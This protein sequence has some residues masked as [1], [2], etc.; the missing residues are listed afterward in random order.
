MHGAGVLRTCG[1]SLSSRSLERPD[2]TGGA[3]PA[4]A[5]RQSSI[6]ASVMRMRRMV[7]VSMP[8]I[9]RMLV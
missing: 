3:V 8:S 2:I 1:R 5:G 6:A 9:M 4:A 7:F